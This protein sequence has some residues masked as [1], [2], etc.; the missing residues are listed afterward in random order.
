MN[1][2][3]HFAGFKMVKG[4]AEYKKLPYPGFGVAVSG[5]AWF[6]GGLSILFGVYVQLGI[7][8]LVIFLLGAAFK[9]HDFWNET[10]I[11]MKMNVQAHFAKNVALAASLLI[12]LGFFK[13]GTG[14]AVHQTGLACKIRPALCQPIPTGWKKFIY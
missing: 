11:N 3:M 13:V 2:I 6:I 14:E 4:Y 9:F 12:I 10:D 7:W 1:G 8:L 5:L